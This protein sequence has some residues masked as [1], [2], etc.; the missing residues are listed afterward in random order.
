M[1]S[2]MVIAIVLAALLAAGAVSWMLYARGRTRRLKRRFGPEYDRAVREAGSQRRAEA[3][4]ESRARRVGML[5]LRE[6]PQDDRDRFAQRWR[7]AQARFVD[8]PAPAVAEASGLVKEVLG[9]RGYP[10]GDFDRRAADISVDHPTV[11]ENY[12]EARQIALASE[13]GQAFTEDL[14]RAM[15]LYRALFEELLGAH[16]YQVQ[17]AHR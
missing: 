5:E 14:R 1:P 10:I 7:E 17:E 9:A 12:R 4:L 2:W 3:E 11:V 15:V 8:E 6:L 16:A 13:R